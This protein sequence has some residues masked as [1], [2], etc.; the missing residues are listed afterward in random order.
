MIPSSVNKTLI[1][2]EPVHNIKNTDIL[3]GDEV[4]IRFYINR[5][6]KY[7][8]VKLTELKY[9][10]YN[11]GETKEFATRLEIN[12]CDRLDKVDD[13]IY[14]IDKIKLINYPNNLLQYYPNPKQL[15]FRCK[16]EEKGTDYVFLLEEA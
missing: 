1:M 11:E 9:N 16:P 6:W 2:L 10:I 7:V 4:Y 5:S 14:P 8:Y 13:N 3:N 12:L 15:F